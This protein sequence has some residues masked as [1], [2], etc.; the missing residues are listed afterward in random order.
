VILSAGATMF[1]PSLRGTAQPPLPS[2]ACD[3]RARSDG[4]GGGWVGEDKE[5]DEHSVAVIWG[6]Q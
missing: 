1:R 6:S 5:R 3:G 4:G 2:H